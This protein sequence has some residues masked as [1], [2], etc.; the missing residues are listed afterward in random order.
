[1]D[2]D[3]PFSSPNSYIQECIHI[4]SLAAG[5]QIHLVIVMGGVKADINLEKAVLNMYA[6]FGNMEDARKLFFSMNRHDLSAWNMMIAG[7][8][9]H[10]RAKE[11]FRLLQEMQLAGMSPDEITFLSVLKGCAN[12]EDAKWVHAQIAKLGFASNLFVGSALLDVYAKCGSIDDAREVFDNM[13]EH[14]VVSWSAMIAG[15][16]QC[17]LSDKAFKL[18]EQM[19]HQHVKPNE[20]TYISMLKAC[21]SFAGLGKVKQIHKQIVQSG[22]ECKLIVGNALVDTY[23]KCGS[24][25][26]ARRVFDTMALRNVISWTAMISGY[27][28]HEHTEDAI[29][30]FKRMEQ[31]GVKANEVTF[32]TLVKLCTG[33]AALEL[34]K[35]IHACIMKSRIKASIFVEN[36][37]ID[38]YVKCSTIEDANSVFNKMPVRDVI[39]WSA[40]IGGYVLHECPEEAFKL[41]QQMG[42]GG[43]MPN[44]VTFISLLMACASLA[45]LDKGKQIHAHIIRCGF[46]MYLFVENTLIDTYCKCGSLEDAH[47]IFNKIPKRDLVSWNALLAGFSQHGHS[48]KAFNLFQ[49]MCEE[50]LTLDHVTFLGLLSVC[51]HA[52]LVDEGHMY[53]D[54]MTQEH[55]IRPTAE[56]CA[57]LV[58]LIGR[59]GR[60]EEAVEFIEKLPFESV[61]VWMA[62]LGASR[63]CGDVHVA[64]LA[65]ESIL[66]LAP[67]NTAAFVLLSNVYAAVGTLV[68]KAKV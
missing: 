8:A 65:T 28:Q 61:M 49:Q 60:L 42:C 45:A 57:C 56:H 32:T 13:S 63:I 3:G 59:T 5:K 31:V 29:K 43:E 4:K 14:N 46:E 47:E 44:D 34:G 68:D 66:E 58:D 53:F 15:Y 36:S 30:L 41:F 16:V 1:M 10:G 35:E 23:A 2:I 50:G 6:R 20:V 67:E 54:L 48:E 52:G 55:G 51:R 39:S 11:A 37:L 62:L 26:N 33:L 24:T 19:E 27:V 38:M 7:Y 40:V 9:K 64:E 21:N 18:F 17:G 12:L 25:Q 22:Y